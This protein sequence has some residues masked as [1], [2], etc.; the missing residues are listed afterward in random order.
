MKFGF[1]TLI[2]KSATE[3]LLNNLCYFPTTIS[4]TA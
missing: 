1:F 4:I 2:F 3:E